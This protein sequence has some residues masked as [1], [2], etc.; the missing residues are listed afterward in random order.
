V[1]I[2]KLTIALGAVGVPQG[3]VVEARVH[4]GATKEVSSWELLLQNWNA[5]Y[6]PG[7]TY[8][9]SV[10]QDGYICIGRGT[11]VPQIITTRTE[12]VKYESNP[13]EN[14]VRVSGRCWGEKLFRQVLTKTYAS[15]KGEAIVKDLLDYY[16]G[17][18][19][20]RASVELVE[21]TST[22][23][24]LLEYENTPVWDI[25]RAIAAASDNAGAIGYDFRVAPDAKFEFFPRNSKSS[26]VSLS[27]KLEQSEYR[28]DIFRVRNR[29]TIYGAPEK[30]SPA[31]KFSSVE[32]LSPTE[33]DW[34]ATA[35]SISLDSSKHYSEAT[36]SIKNSTGA[37]Y[38]GAS[39][40]TFETAYIVDADKFPLLFLV[41]A[42]DSALPGDFSIILYDNSDRVAQ[43]QINQ[44]GDDKWVLE[45]LKVGS[46]YADQWAVE[47]NFDWTHIWR[48]K[49]VGWCTDATPGN[50]WVGQLFF[51]G[52][53][54]SSMQENVASQTAYGLR[55]YVDTDEELYSDNECMLRAK[56][57]LANL[58]EPAEYLTVRSTVIDYGTTPLLSGDKI[59]V[60]LPSE[61]VN[62]N[63]RILSVEYLV[64][65]KTQ[66]LEITLELGREIPLLAD[67]M[68]ALRSKIGHVSRYKKAR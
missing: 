59:T 5:K 11:N 20:V 25:I 41:L 31:D 52:C 26:S 29:I 7:G 38:Y 24:T 37:N 2:P 49:V 12:S 47:A 65:A 51:G 21:N 42:R 55:M 19:H 64:D 27:E 3:D 46:A 1:E 33:G 36:A 30:S 22:T 4:L 61:N 10:G 43:C 9:L 60:V 39:L 32:S 68:Y 63:F 6:S 45:Q 50:F 8:P 40:F 62:A 35:G 67:Y 56:A 14:Y 66:T 15:Q 28:K 44:I 13:S 23:F 18:S 16:S 54:Y 48:V 58:K 57:I 34:T 17:L 53:R